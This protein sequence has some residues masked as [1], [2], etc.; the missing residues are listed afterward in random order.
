MQNQER[1]EEVIN[2]IL[3]VCKTKGWSA[4]LSSRDNNF[5]FATISVSKGFDYENVSGVVNVNLDSGV[6]LSIEKTSFHGYGQADLLKAM[7]LKLGSLSWLEKKD[8]KSRTSPSEYSDII[9]RV[10]SNFDKVVRQL[11]RRYK[12]R[13][14]IAVDDEYDVQDILHALLRA[15]FGDVRP[16]EY[17]PSHAG[18][19][20]RVD[21]LLKEEKSV[22]EVKYATE[23]LKGGKIGE[24]L[25]ID[26]KRY[27]THPDCKN[28]YCLVYDPHGQ[29]N[30]PVG[31]EK[32]LSGKHGE[33]QVT[34]LVVPH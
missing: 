8:K 2:T 12:D 26:M 29:V 7:S 16:E 28:L 15:Y 10:L 32:D 34:V 25:I 19:S 23:K 20:S 24:Q 22:I 14:S 3:E 11:R 31:L 17:T 27:Q 21:F 33:L 6:S 5:Q 13:A 1:Y 9:V 30:N 4:K 18:S